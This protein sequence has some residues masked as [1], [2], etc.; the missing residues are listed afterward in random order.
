MNKYY[1][2]ALATVLFLTASCSVEQKNESETI[3]NVF[4]ESPL[5]I[6]DAVVHTFPAT[7]EE[8]RTISVGFKTAGQIEQIFVKEG[9]QVT[10]GQ[11][12]AMLDTVDYSLGISTLRER[13]RQL[14]IET[15]RRAKLH[16]SGNMSV[17]DY[18]NAVSGLRQ[19]QLQLQLEENKLEYCQLK[20]PASGVVTKINF[21]NSEMVDAG[22]PVI[23]LMDNSHLEAIVD[24][25][26]RYYAK[27]TGFCEFIGELSI[28]PD[29]TVPLTLLSI[30]PKADNSMLYT[31]RLGLPQNAEGIT[32]GMNMRVKI[33]SEATDANS[34]SISLNALF[35]REGQTYVWVV[36][37]ADNTISATPIT[38]AGTGENGRVEVI[39]GLS[40]NDIVVRAGVHHL[41]DGE[42]VNILTDESTTNPGNVL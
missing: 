25:P 18:E 40:V 6:G 16:A 32:P 26:V 33:V 22:T 30:T 1:I 24:L 21:E 2:P 11:R 12:I 28:S 10:A 35:D 4:V 27:R 37:P 8:A 13:Y 15:E 14:A 38:I 41:S 5:P 36:N 9:Q 7:V 20:S 29:K 3:H 42:K 31:L 19:L 17:N 23:E 39:N 34:V